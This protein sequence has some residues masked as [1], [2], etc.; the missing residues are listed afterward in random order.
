MRATRRGKGAAVERLSSRIWLI[1]QNSKTKEQA[2]LV[3]LTKEGNEERKGGR[4]KNFS[5]L[6]KMKMHVP[7]HA[8]LKYFL[9]L[10]QLPPDARLDT[11]LSIANRLQRLL[12]MDDV[13]LQPFEGRRGGTCR[14][15]D[16]MERG[17]FGEDVSGTEVAVQEM[18]GSR[19][20]IRALELIKGQRR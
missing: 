15:E 18:I 5:S 3:S 16:G 19:V 7:Q 10:L 11:T 1:G 4:T 17:K 20:V 6:D 14:S 13:D 12:D 9:A 8:S 2:T